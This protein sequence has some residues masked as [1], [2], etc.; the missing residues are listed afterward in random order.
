MNRRDAQMAENLLWL[1]RERYPGR[2][3]I[4][5][6]AT[7]HISRN[8]QLIQK[9]LADPGMVP[10][11][12]HL[13]QAVGPR[14]Y[15]IAFTS[16]R[17]QVATWRANAWDLAP[18]RRGSLERA[19]AD[20]PGDTWFIDLRGTVRPGDRLAGPVVARPMG[21]ARMTAA[22]PEIVDGFVFIRTA[23][24]SLERKE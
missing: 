24:P 12:H 2:K 13:W 6:A 15:A 18:P 3:I 7:S 9:P 10:M 11:G 16:A 1:A 20:V 14:A 8:R 22:W 19:L 23:E 5:W 4:I 21:Y 17:G